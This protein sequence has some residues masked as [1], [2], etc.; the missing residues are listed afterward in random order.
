MLIAARDKLAPRIV[1]VVSVVSTTGFIALLASCGGGNPSNA[2]QAQSQIQ[3]DAGKLPPI[4]SA[5]ARAVAGVKAGEGET[6]GPYGQDGSEYVLA[7]QDEFEGDSLDDSKWTD[8]IWYE[9]SSPTRDYAVSGGTLKIWPQADVDGRIADRILVTDQKHYQTYGYF[10]MEAKLPVGAGVWPAF[11]LLNSDDSD[12]ASPEIDVMEA[13]SGDTSGYWADG[14]KHP[15][16][17]GASWY[18]NGANFAGRESKEA[19]FTGDLSTEFHKYGLKWEPN[20]LSFYFDGKLVS[21]SN[22]SMSKRMYMLVDVQYG[23]ASGSPDDTTPMG[24]S[25]ALEVNYVRSWKFQ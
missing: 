23:S 18:E 19:P 17:Y 1:S 24:T 8:H 14:D 4:Q 16:R 20:K 25:N 5:V 21:T 6:P 10:E 7:F 22:V 15:I 3:V 13:Y 12:N 2:P 9:R 11:W